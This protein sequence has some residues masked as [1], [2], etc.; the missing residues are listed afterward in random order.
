MTHIGR[1]NPRL[2]DANV[3]GT[4]TSVNPAEQRRLNG[5]L[6]HL[7]R[8]KKKRLGTLEWSQR[9]FFIKQV[10][11]HN[12]DLRFV[13]ASERPKYLEDLPPLLDD[14]IGV[15][16]AKDE[17]NELTKSPRGGL[18]PPPTSPI[19][20][21][22][23]NDGEESTDVHDSED[24]KEQRTNSSGR[25]NLEGSSL[26]RH[27]SETSQ[28][29]LP[30]IKVRAMGLFARS[31]TAENASEKKTE[32]VHLP[33]TPET[34]RRRNF[35]GDHHGNSKVSSPRLP[36][37][38][39]DGVI[40]SPSVSPQT[41]I[42][43]TQALLSP[44]IYRR[45]MSARRSVDVNDLRMLKSQR[46]REDL[47]SSPS[48]IRRQRSQS[49]PTIS[50]RGSVD[51]WSRMFERRNGSLSYGGKTAGHL[52]TSTESITDSSDGECDEKVLRKLVR[53]LPTHLLLKTR[54]REKETGSRS[55]GVEEMKRKLLEK[56][57]LDCNQRTVEDPRFK[58]LA[59]SLTEN[60]K[61]RLV[62]I[63]QIID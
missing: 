2:K 5:V 35:S 60:N 56:C 22:I 31:S 41:S 33:P 63:D 58:S 25:D 55:A 38:S 6:D 16:D 52:A 8:E 47:L 59:N 12:N 26:Q 37:A 51:Q 19:P 29:K 42:T 17:L 27:G 9:E 34:A 44:A 50:P 10:F 15:T 20:E 45:H 39:N 7:D 4:L 62:N 13:K 11:D 30:V 53:S 43:T 32:K 49:K 57:R 28:W 48:S 1:D 36:A 18:N 40:Q 14:V 61:D 46:S 3:G 24:F 21:E 54:E 23:S